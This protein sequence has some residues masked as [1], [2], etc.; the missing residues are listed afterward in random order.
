MRTMNKYFIF[1]AAF[2]ALAS[3]SNDSFVG[4]NS[5]TMGGESGNGGAI[6]FSSGTNGI[7]RANTIG[8]DAAALLGNNFV[9]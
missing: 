4:D 6:V 7:T 8:A 1:A 9:E 3:C 2:V 5:P